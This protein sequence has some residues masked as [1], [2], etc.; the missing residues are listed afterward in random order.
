MLKSFC[1]QAENEALQQLVL[2]V[3]QNKQDAHRRVASLRDKY[4]ALLAKVWACLAHTPLPAPASA[5]TS[6]QLH[7]DVE[8]VDDAVQMMLHQ[9]VSGESYMLGKSSC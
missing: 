1:L 7:E 3:A 4:S 2:E 6:S 5:W 8:D 9:L